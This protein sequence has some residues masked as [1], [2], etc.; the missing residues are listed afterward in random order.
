MLGPTS[1]GWELAVQQSMTSV[2]HGARSCSDVEMSAFVASGTR[3][4]GSFGTAYVVDIGGPSGSLLEMC[5]NVSMS[6]RRGRE[7]WTRPGRSTIEDVSGP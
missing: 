2:G 3:V 6:S 7:L 4:V 5:W 1:A